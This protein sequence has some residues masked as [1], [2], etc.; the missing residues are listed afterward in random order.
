MILTTAR[1]V[2]L[3]N[4]NSAF[5]AFDLPLALTYNESFEQPIFGANYIK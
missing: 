1:I 3:N 5:K 4:K 2:C